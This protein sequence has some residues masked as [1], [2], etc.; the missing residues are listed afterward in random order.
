VFDVI[1]YHSNKPNMVMG[2]DIGPDPKTFVAKALTPIG[3]L[4]QSE[5]DRSN[6]CVQVPPEQEDDGIV[7]LPQMLPEE[8]SV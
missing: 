1:I 2:L 7:S 6:K 3:A 5:L 4:P 8:A